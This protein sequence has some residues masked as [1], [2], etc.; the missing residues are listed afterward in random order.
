MSNHSHEATV[1]G[2]SGGVDSSVAAWL[3]AEEGCRV[4]GAT[5]YTQDSS[6]CCNNE[7]IARARVICRDLGIPYRLLDLRGSFQKLV[8]DQFV[9]T[10]LDARTPNPCITCNE[11]L[12]F[13][14]FYR[15]ART[16]LIE[17]GQLRERDP[18]YIATGHYA[19]LEKADGRTFIKKGADPGKDQSYMLYRIPRDVLPFVRFPLGDYLKSEVVAIAGRENLPT[20][21]IKESQDICFAD[22][23]YIGFLRRCLGEEKVDRPGK[24]TDAS[25]RQ[26]GIHRGYLHYTIGQ[27]QGLGLAD[28]P[29]YVASINAEKNLVVVARKEHLGDSSF[30]VSNILWDIPEDPPLQCNVKIRYN[31]REVPCRVSGKPTSGQLHVELEEKAGVTPGQSAVFYRDDLVI[32]GGIIER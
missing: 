12:R 11:Q 28:G 7:T 18:L 19:R 26:I 20:K 16:L 31:S 21:S 29:W 8:V 22:G 25:G 2:L 24:I 3:L 1:I 15:D 17:E 5:H 4:F 9:A 30:T 10:Y 14:V 23:N 27:R 13:D 32:G 6:P